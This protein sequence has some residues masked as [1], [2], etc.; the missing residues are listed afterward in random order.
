VAFTGPFDDKPENGI[1]A[2]AM[3][4]MLQGSLSRTLREDLGGT[5]GVSV[6][7]LFQKDPVG[8][9][10]LTIDFS[11]DPERTDALTDAMFRVIDQFKRQGP[12]RGQVTDAR[13]A[14]ARDDEVNSRDNSYLV[15]QIAFA[16]QN[17]E[18]VETVLDRG[19]YYNGLTTAA[20]QDAARRYLDESRYVQVTLRPESQPAS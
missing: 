4:E 15:S 3:A 16:Y 19:A 1:T 9:Y 17:G 18:D 20:I 5:Y 14:F 8:A 2:R 6:Q 13:T 10:R 7:P 12:T 11:C